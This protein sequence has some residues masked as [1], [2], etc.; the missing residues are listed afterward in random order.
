M[1]RRDQ[2]VFSEL[3]EEQSWT[4]DFFPRGPVGEPPR[5]LI[6]SWQIGSAGGGLPGS[7]LLAFWPSQ[8]ESGLAP[9]HP[10]LNYV[11]LQRVQF[12]M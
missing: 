7:C 6:Q 9:L 2:R 1:V 4:Q 12:G 5:P 8:A 3:W 10:G 11:S